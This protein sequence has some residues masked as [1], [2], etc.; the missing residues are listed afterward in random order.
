M[1]CH[2]RW[3]IWSEDVRSR[4]RAVCAAARAK[5]GDPE[6]A[7]ID[8]DGW[9][10]VSLDERGGRKVYVEAQSLEELEKAVTT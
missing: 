2:P 7:V 5:W 1:N 8:L 6:A 3:S 9:R 10:I 4:A